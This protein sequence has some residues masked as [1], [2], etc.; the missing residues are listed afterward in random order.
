M[1]IDSAIAGRTTELDQTLARQ[2]RDRGAQS[3]AHL[4]IV[5]RPRSRGFTAETLR[6]RLTQLVLQRKSARR[7]RPSTT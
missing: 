5:N 1:D 6:T 4:L 2:A 7:M 3:L